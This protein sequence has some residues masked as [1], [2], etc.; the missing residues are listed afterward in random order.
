MN[1]KELGENIGLE[2][3][4]YRELAELFLDTGRVDYDRLKTAFD[5]GDAQQVA[6]SAHTINGAAGNMGLMNIHEAAK[7]IEQAAGENL[8]DSVRGEVGALKG[9]FDEIDGA[10]HA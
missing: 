2:E 7:Q 3:D 8:L 10:V 1:F 5:A 4:D 9:L 6:R